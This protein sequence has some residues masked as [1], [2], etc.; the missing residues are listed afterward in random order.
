M[1]VEL[2]L[3]LHQQGDIVSAQA[4]YKEILDKDPNNFNGLH[5]LGLTYYQQGELNRAVE[6]IAKAISL[7]ANYALA[8]FHLGCALQDSDYWFRSLESYDRAIS[9]EPANEQAHL[10]RVEV[11]IKLNRMLDALSGCSRLVALRPKSHLAYYK[12]AEINLIL[13][14]PGDAL[15]DYKKSIE[16][17]D[18]FIEGHFSLANALFDL[19]KFD[20]SLIHYQKAI[21]IDPDYDFLYGFYIQNKMRMCDWNNISDELQIFEKQL[22]NGQWATF[23]FIPLNLFD[24]PK[25][26]Q[27]VAVAYMQKKYSLKKIP[28]SNSIKKNKK[29]IRIGYYSADFRVHPTSQLMVEILRSHD[30]SQFDIYGFSFG[31]EQSDATK[32]YISTIFDK[33]IEVSSFSD[34]QIVKLS[35]DLEID[36]AIELGGHTQY[37]R[38][39]VFVAR[40]APVQINYLAYPGTSGCDHMDYIMADKNII[41]DENKEF[42]TE[43]K[44]YLPHCYVTHDSKNT[45][46][47]DKLNRCD[48]GLKDN[49]FIFCCFNSSFKILPETFSVWMRILKSVDASM[50]WLL[51]DNPFAVKNILKEAKNRGVDPN[52]LV[53]ARR[54]HLD[55]HLARHR[56]ADLFLDTL[57][58]NAHTTANDSLW[59]GLPVLTLIGQSFAS[60]VAASLLRAIELPELICHT[61]DEY[62]ARAIELALDPKKLVILR[63][64]LALNKYKAPLFNGPL[65]TRDIESAYLK[66]YQ[67]HIK[68]LMPEDIYLSA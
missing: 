17:K 46:P 38:T 27:K 68:G 63:E 55:Q 35:K 43:K 9:I 10:K 48:F 4:I 57:P 32:K 22:S 6:L 12:R 42:F 28:Y 62:E 60:R 21:D 19:R 8:H 45:I 29:K 41:S 3:K 11:L 64:K 47:E 65:I 50:L 25:L 36:I 56:L 2:A 66:V 18:N 20:E 51:Q 61:Q 7:D 14:R 16:L 30:R 67:R 24:K 49:A 31:P 54:L 37:A 5:L 58:Y 39:G 44:I 1:K 15:L 23:P 59:A 33:F 53:F 13:K 52:R 34:H 40:C 26:H